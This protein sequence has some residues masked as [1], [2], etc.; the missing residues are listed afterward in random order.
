MFKSTCIWR[1][2]PCCSIMASSDSKGPV[3]SK[4]SVH[5]KT[6]MASQG[7]QT[8]PCIHLHN[9]QILGLVILVNVLWVYFA[10]ANRLCYKLVE[11]LTPNAAQFSLFCNTLWYT[12]MRLQDPNQSMTWTVRNHESI[13]ESV[14]NSGGGVP[15]KPWQW[16]QLSRWCLLCHLL[17]AQSYAK[18][19]QQVSDFNHSPF[20]ALRAEHR[21]KAYLILAPGQDACWPRIQVGNILLI[22]C[23]CDE[24]SLAWLNACST[25]KN[26]LRMGRIQSM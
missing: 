25:L 16:S 24:D 4:T 11:R 12:I 23:F 5:D 2:L 7:M 20:A 8:S 26:R 1:H 9:H 13:A 15:P 3:T 10:K 21:K 14:W 17:S 18:L 19:L 6:S 22:D